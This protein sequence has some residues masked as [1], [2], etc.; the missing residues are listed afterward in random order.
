MWARSSTTGSIGFGEAGIGFKSASS[1][2]DFSIYRA[3]DED[4]RTRLDRQTTS[5]A[6]PNVHRAVLLYN[7][8][9]EE[10]VIDF[11]RASEYSRLWNNMMIVGRHC[12][13][14]RGA[15]AEQGRF[16]GTSFGEGVSSS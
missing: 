2:D 8:I 13:G 3:I 12:R 9:G 14:Q 1:I 10:R 7:R 15:K 11:R 4:V 16:H 6:A 5:D